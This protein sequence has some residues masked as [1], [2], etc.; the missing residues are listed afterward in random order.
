MKTVIGNRKWEIETEAENRLPIG[1]NRPLLA[2]RFRPLALAFASALGP[3]FP[4]PVL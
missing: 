4:I 3:R 2:D 1:E